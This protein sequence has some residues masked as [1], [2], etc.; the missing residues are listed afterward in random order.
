MSRADR[1]LLRQS[2][3]VFFKEHIEDIKE[4]LIQLLEEQEGI[5]FIH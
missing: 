4:T 1:P 5:K 3:F 2:F